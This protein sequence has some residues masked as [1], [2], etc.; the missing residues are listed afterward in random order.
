[1]DTAIRIIHRIEDIPTNNRFKWL[2]KKIILWEDSR[3]LQKHTTDNTELIR[4]H[5]GRIVYNFFRDSGVQMTARIPHIGRFGILG[6][7][8]PC[9]Q[10][11][12]NWIGDIPDMV[13]F[14]YMGESI[15]IEQVGPVALTT[16]NTKFFIQGGR[17]MYM[18][19]MINNYQVNCFKHTKLIPLFG[20]F[21]VLG[22]ELKDL[23]KC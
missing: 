3:F 18:S 2:G 17:V 4:T 5:D 9:E 23:K 16:K 14:K 19:R 22:Y 21:K 10:Y 8:T 11:V 15:K 13:F 20:E 1:M 12:V 7:Y 6:G